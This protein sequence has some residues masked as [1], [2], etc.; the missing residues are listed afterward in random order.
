MTDLKK[1]LEDL[2]SGKVTV[3]EAEKQLRT[4]SLDKIG[5]IATIDL[6]R[7]TRSGVPEVVFAESKDASDIASIWVF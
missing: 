1:I 4:I 5:S 3:D 2:N 6:D 7:E